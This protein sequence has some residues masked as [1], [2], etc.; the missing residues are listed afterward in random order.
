MRKFT[1]YLIILVLALTLALPGAARAQSSLTPTWSSEIAYYNPAQSNI[2][3]DGSDLGTAEMSIIYYKSTGGSENSGTIPVLPH[4]SGVLLVGSTSNFKGSAVIS[5]DKP[6]MAVY[7]QEATGREPFS[8]ILYTSF[9][10]TQAGEGDFFLPAVQRTELFDTQIG[11]QNIGSTYIEINMDF[12]D[13]N[14]TSYHINEGDFPKAGNPPTDEII[15]QASRIFKASDIAGL[16]EGFDGSLVIHAHFSGDPTKAGVVAVAQ[17]ILVGGR[18]AYTYEGTGAGAP[19][20]YM[21]AALCK[22]GSGQQTTRYWVQNSGS[23]VTTISINYYDNSATS[24]FAGWTSSDPIAPGARK[25]VNVCDATP[26]NPSTS[27]MTGKSLSAVISSGSSTIAAVGKTTSTDGLYT[28]FTG[29]PLPSLPVGD[30]ADNGTF[31]VELPYV[32]Y[33]TNK[34]GYKTYISIQNADSTAANDVTVS[35][36]PRGSSSPIVTQTLN[37]IQPGAMMGTDASLARAFAP[38]SRGFF[39]AVEIT[40][41]HPL[42]ALARVQ[43]AVTAPNVSVLGEDYSGLL[44]TNQTVSSPAP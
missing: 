19:K 1:I 6:L 5:S 12:Y 33:A 22:V 39:G 38:G 2:Q 24:P 11:I 28:G 34:N 27:S 44:Y 7:K 14:G 4:Y 30:M 3:S 37:P 18:Q 15:P 26:T 40:S 35:F 10:L 21:P 42:V 20:V 29:Q 25:V 13:N 43:Y 41:A 32:E 8:P 9:D 36:Y 31:H 17:D 16:P 23:A